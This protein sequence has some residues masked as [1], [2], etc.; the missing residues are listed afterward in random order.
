MW[1]SRASSFYGNRVNAELGSI[2]YR[3]CL[4]FMLKREIKTVNEE[5]QRIRHVSSEHVMNLN[6]ANLTSCETEGCSAGGAGN[7]L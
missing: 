4:W 7:G 1:L 5:R 3:Y 2:N 6:I